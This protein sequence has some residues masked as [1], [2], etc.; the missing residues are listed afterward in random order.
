M[1]ARNRRYA[2]VVLS[3]LAVALMSTGLALAA[4]APTATTAPATNI[5]STTATLNGIVAAN[6]TP[7]TYHFQYGTT[8]SYGRNTP[9]ATA[10]G[11]ASKTVS[12]DVT[13]LTASTTYHF[14]I[15]ATST[16]G[17]SSGADLTFT[18]AA[19][20]TGGPSKNSVSISAIPP[21]ITWGHTANI[22]GS[23][24]GP[25]KAGQTV[26]LEANPYPYTAGFKPTGATTTTSSSGA[27]SLT[28]RP[29]R[30]TRYEVIVSTK[31]PVTS[32]PTTVRVR[33]KVAI[34]VSTLR[35]FRGHLVRFYGTVTPA[36][37]G[38]Y[39]QIQRRTSTGA[40]RTVTSTRLLAGGRVNGVAVSKYAKRIRIRHSGT[41]RVRVNPRDGD[42]LSANSATR[43]ER[44]R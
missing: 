29:R 5:T 33:V 31:T 40:W 28:V 14:R 15:V 23:V 42:H 36:H 34:H 44:V 2:L 41:Y 9:T 17:T 8:T 30:N 20:G 19:T 4:P 7:T 22:A 18:T 11:N 43:T 21:T 35:P 39:A 10:N 38:R 6:K 37:N 16:S 3:A 26:T 25:G 32:S 24:T 27:Y 1:T 12:A 13:G